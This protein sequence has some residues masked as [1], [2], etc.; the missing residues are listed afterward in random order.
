MDLMCSLM[1]GEQPRMTPVFLENRTRRT[2]LPFIE[3]GRLAKSRCEWVCG[4]GTQEGEGCTKSMSKDLD[5]LAS[6]CLLDVQ[7]E[8][9][10]RQ[11]NR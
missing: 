11:Q 6:M 5:V 7:G 8:M 4:R 2:E 9:L 3:V 10:S 1:K